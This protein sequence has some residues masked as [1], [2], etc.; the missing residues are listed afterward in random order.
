MFVIK[1]FNKYIND[2]NSIE[3]NII[4]I[5]LIITIFITLSGA[6]ILTMVFAFAPDIFAEAT[7]MANTS[8]RTFW[9]HM[10]EALVTLSVILF[11]STLI[12]FVRRSKSLKIKP[13]EKEASI[14]W[15]YLI[16]EVCLY[17][18]LLYFQRLVV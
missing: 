3:K 2:Q 4:T 7:N 1:I 10:N 15:A 16:V 12:E 13:T 17:N 9:D 14:F 18:F 6:I 8:D 5:F 11:I